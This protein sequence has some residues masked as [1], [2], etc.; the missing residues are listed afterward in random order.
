MA[1]SNLNVGDF[2]MVLAAGLA[3]GAV[4]MFAMQSIKGVS[5]QP[6]S[7][8]PPAIQ[9]K[10][11]SMYFAG[12]SEVWDFRDVGV[13]PHQNIIYNKL[14]WIE[15]STTTEWNPENMPFIGSYSACSDCIGERRSPIAPARVTNLR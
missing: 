10:F 14:T 2:G 12:K 6:P 8:T 3:I 5:L 11:G 1:V 4:G 7:L 13:H 9:S 15:L